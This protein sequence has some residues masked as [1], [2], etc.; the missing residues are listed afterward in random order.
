MII[1]ITAGALG[2]KC[3]LCFLPFAEAIS[4]GEVGINSFVL[5]TGCSAN[6]LDSRAN[7]RYEDVEKE[8]KRKKPHEKKKL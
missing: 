6:D 4:Y 7:D 3:P 2:K 5:I 8:K 1:E